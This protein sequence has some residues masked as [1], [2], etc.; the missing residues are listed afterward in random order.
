VPLV[1]LVG[2]TDE[3]VRITKYPVGVSVPGVKLTLTEVGVVEESDNAVGC[4]AGVAQK[5]SVHW[6]L[7]EREVV[8][9]V[10]AE[11]PCV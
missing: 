2:A 4:V 5:G 8:P 11:L 7:L 3:F 10:Q 9:A 1:G 6:T